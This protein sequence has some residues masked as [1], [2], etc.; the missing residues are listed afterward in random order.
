MK[1]GAMI[2]G[3]QKCGTTSLADWIA[4]HPDVQ[5]CDQKEPEYF[6]RQLD[7]KANLDTYHGLYQ[8]GPGSQNESKLLMEASTNYSWFLEFPHV[9]KSLHDYNADMKLIYIV[10]NP[11]GRIK[12]HY[13]HNFLKSYTQR[14]FSEDVFVNPEYIA[15][16]SY[17]MQI[18]KYIEL[19]GLSNILFLSFED[20]IADELAVLNK[21]CEFLGLRSLERNEI[22]FSPKNVSAELKKVSP[23]KKFIA[24]FFRFLPLK[25]R[26]KFRGVLYKAHEVQIDTNEQI[27]ARLKHLLLND[28]KAF[29][30]ISGIRYF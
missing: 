7:W 24:P 30:A 3:V 22:D 25:V 6:S 1:V 21:T 14:S 26:L 15:H 17:E 23:L 28:I 4:Q 29:E 16:S 13:K 12:S 18:R 10:R 19:F 9:P 11:I 5:F 27:E 8:V 2:I 20:L